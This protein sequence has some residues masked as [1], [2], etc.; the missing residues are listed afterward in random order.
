MAENEKRDEKKELTGSQE[1]FLSSKLSPGKED[2]REPRVLQSWGF[3]P[4]AILKSTRKVTFT[5]HVPILDK[6]KDIITA[7]AIA[8]AIP[9]YMHLPILHDFH[10]DR[11]IGIATKVWQTIYNEFQ[12][13]GVIKSTSDCDD[14]WLKVESGKYDHVSI[15]G[16]RTE[17]SEACRVRSEARNEPCVNTGIRLDSISACDDN[18]RNPSTSLAVSKASVVYDFEESLIKGETADSSLIHSAFEGAAKMGE[19]TRA[20]QGMTPASKEEVE[21]CAPSCSGKDLSKAENTDAEP[22]APNMEPR[23]ADGGLPSLVTLGQKI[24]ALTSI[25]NRLVESDKQVH[26]EMNKAKEETSMEDNPEKKEAKQEEI[27]KAAP[28]APPVTEPAAPSLKES[29]VESLV[30]ARLESATA[31]LMAELTALKAQVKKMEDETI[32][33]AAFVIIPEH[34]TEE[35]KKVFNNVGM[36]NAY[37]GGKAR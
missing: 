9:D 8:K 17:Y 27:V 4:N 14:V 13:E 10:K 18:A 7:E 32:Q 25:V 36:L 35:Q 19:E 21:K 15:G 12:G 5:F 24:D 1:A 2:L 20:E 30:K 28:P 26:S 33:K 34:L 16:K 22:N 23:H 31:P 11:P 29:D 37:T 6:D 3:D